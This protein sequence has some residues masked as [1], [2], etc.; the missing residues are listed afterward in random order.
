MA[1]VIQKKPYL[2]KLKIERNP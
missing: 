2:A 1:K